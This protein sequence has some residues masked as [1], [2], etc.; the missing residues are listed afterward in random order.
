MTPGTTRVRR[1]QVA[2]ALVA[3]GTAVVFS[4][5]RPGLLGTLRA[6]F[7]I[8]ENDP[9]IRGRI[10][11]YA[12]V[13]PMINE[14]PWW[15]R[16]TGTFV[17]E[18]YPLLDNQWLLTMVSSGIIGV[19]GSLVLM[20]TGIGLGVAVWR[21]ATL[22][23]DRHLAACLVAGLVAFAFAAATFDA[24][25]FTTYVVTFGLLLGVVGALWRISLSGRSHDGH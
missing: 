6:L 13:F 19:A 8:S 20:C 10:E 24:L 14:R 1:A 22:E 7:T 2:V 11:N 12:L 23:S 9:S 21:R 17:P 16:G 15:G 5:I 25:F 3:V 4:G 18:L